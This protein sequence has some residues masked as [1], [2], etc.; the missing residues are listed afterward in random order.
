MRI[1]NSQ[2]IENIVIYIFV[3]YLIFWYIVGCYFSFPN[4]EDYSLSYPSRDYGILDGAFDNLINVDGRYTTNFLHGLNPLV[5][6]WII[7][8][9]LMNFFTLCLLFY[10]LYFLCNSF[11]FLQK[12]DSIKLAL[13][14]TVVFFNSSPSPVHQFFNMS[15]SFVYLYPW[16]SVLFWLGSIIRFIKIG[17]ENWFFLSLLLMYLSF[18][19][20][21]LFLSIN[22]FFVGYIV[23]VVEKKNINT[24]RKIILV[25]VYVIAVV[26]MIS[27]QGNFSRLESHESDR[28][29]YDFLIILSTA[30]K[31][32]SL[33]VVNLVIKLDFLVPIFLIFRILIRYNY[34]KTINIKNFQHTFILFVFSFLSTFIYYLPMG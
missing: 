9:K 8:Y 30:S 5:I 27:S 10:S 29:G 21:E 13:L 1:L 2:R 6:D 20:N 26:T 17:K 15:G 28:I 7:G 14:I 12:K 19:F 31:N 22:S 3:I 32:F 23:L 25:L 34:F 24:K 18:G 4:A 16:I 11:Q 33:Y